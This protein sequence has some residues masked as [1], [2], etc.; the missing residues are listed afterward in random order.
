MPLKTLFLLS[1][2][3]T[4]GP[5]LSHDGSGKVVGL[6]AS[7]Q[8]VLE[9]ARLKGMAPAID[10]TASTGKAIHLS[11]FAKKPIVLV[12]IERDCPYTRAAKSYYDQIQFAYRNELTVLGVIDSNVDDAGEWTEAAVPKFRLILDPDLKIAKSYGATNGLHTVLISPDQKIVKMWPGFS[13]SMLGE[14]CTLANQMGAKPRAKP[15]FGP[16]PERLTCGNPLT[17]QDKKG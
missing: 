4:Q 7:P 16:A 3:L 12:F 11:D 5:A 14:L 1:I 15:K 13:K 6:L 9:A 8:S 10:G 17:V 2:S